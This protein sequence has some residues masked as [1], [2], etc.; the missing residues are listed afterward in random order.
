MSRLLRIGRFESA[1]DGGRERD[2]PALVLP[3]AADAHPKY[4]NDIRVVWGT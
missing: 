2:W 1:A 4:G 3:A